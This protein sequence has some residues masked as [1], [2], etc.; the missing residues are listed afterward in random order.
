MATTPPPAPPKPPTP[1]SLADPKV[2][3]VRI[4][5]VKLSTATYL[6][7][8]VNFAIAFGVM[9]LVLGVLAFLA[10][11]SIGILGRPVQ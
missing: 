5:E 6:T 1:V 3:D 10:L 11:K 9:F 8:A 4:V 7:I 2:I